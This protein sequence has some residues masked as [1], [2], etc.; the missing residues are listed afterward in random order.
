MGTR[1]DRPLPLLQAA[2]DKH[3]IRC[4]ER[5]QRQ[6]D[7]TPLQTTATDRIPRLHEQGRR[8]LS[9]A[10]DPRDS[11]QSLDP[12]AEAAFLGLDQLK[13]HINDFIASYNDNAR[14]FVWAKSKVHQK[15]LMPCF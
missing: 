5:R 1:V 8:R 10:R 2:W 9:R 15:R 14:P 6:G 7:W 12:Q 4:A 11:R 13:A 3:A